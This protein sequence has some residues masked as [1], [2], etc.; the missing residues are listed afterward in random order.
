MEEAPGRGAARAGFFHTMKETKKVTRVKATKDVLRGLTGV[1]ESGATNT[2]DRPVGVCRCAARVLRARPQGFCYAIETR[3]R[4]Y[5][6]ADLFDFLREHDLGYVF[7]EGYYMP[8]IGNIFREHDTRTA[9]VS[10]IRLHGPDRKGIEEMTGST[11]DGIVAP[12][13]ESLEAATEIVRANRRAGIQTFVNINNHLE[14]C[15]PLTAE[16]SLALLRKE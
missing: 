9:C 16:R 4:N 5:L 6:S 8:H 15:A 7:L 12:K 11:W 2:L 3:N 1:R 14:G 13:P 10:V